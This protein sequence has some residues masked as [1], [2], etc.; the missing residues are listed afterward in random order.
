MN[1][2]GISIFYGSTDRETCLAE[3]RPAIGV[4]SAVITLQ[5]SKTLRML[6]FTRM[7]TAY[8]ALSYFQSDFGE[9]AERFSFL[10]ELGGRI[11]QP[12]VPGREADYLITQTMMEY[13]A[14]VHRC[15]FDGVLF[16][17]S[18]RNSGK[19]IALFAEMKQDR[20]TFPLEYVAGSLS[21]H[22]TQAITYEH[23]ET[24]YNFDGETV[25]A[26]LDVS[27][28]MRLLPDRSISGWA[29]SGEGG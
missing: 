24:K 14:H 20:P 3:L 27:L 22:A 7:R 10:R 21:I 26:E 6:D 4:E 17:S 25:Q 15:P 9:Q 1:A 29:R 16:N 8:K 19:N 18:Q 2:E 23:K 12:V 28:L 5:T 13:L 11:S